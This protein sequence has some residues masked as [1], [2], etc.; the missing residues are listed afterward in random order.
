MPPRVSRSAV[1]RR[2]AVRIVRLGR[3]R[4]WSLYDTRST[5]GR[6]GGLQSRHTTAAVV[7]NE[8]DPLLLEDLADLLERWAP[9]GARYRHN[10]LGSIRFRLNNPA[11]GPP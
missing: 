9:A 7:V 6:C 1:V 11:G 3:D 5:V 4:P 10:D 2:A 8:N